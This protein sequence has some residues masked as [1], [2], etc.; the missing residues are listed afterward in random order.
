MIAP[1]C[2]AVIFLQ[3]GSPE[4]GT[5]TNV[6]PE[7]ARSNRVVTPEARIFAVARPAVVTVRCGGSKGSGFLIDAQG[8]IVTNDHVI[9][10]GEAVQVRRMD[11]RLYAAQV[12]ARDSKADVAVIRANPVVFEGVAPLPLA[13]PEDD[14][15]FEG[16][17]LVVIGSPLNQEFIVTSGI[18]S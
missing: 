11:G 4:V 16:E 12:L 15:P 14:P 7:Q 3:V 17:R 5:P 9:N 1:I 10:S 2:L 8:L 18:V 6:I 13:G